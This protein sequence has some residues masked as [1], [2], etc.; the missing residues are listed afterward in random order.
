MKFLIPSLVYFLLHPSCT[1]LD[2]Q[3]LPAAAAVEKR[4]RQYHWALHHH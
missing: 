1:L 4:V 3:V 2:G